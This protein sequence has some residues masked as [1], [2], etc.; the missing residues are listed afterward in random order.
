MAAGVRVK[1]TQEF[2]TRRGV[3]RYV[4]AE[5]QGFSIIESR[6]F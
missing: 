3:M 4:K 5:Y 1:A 6:C 2:L